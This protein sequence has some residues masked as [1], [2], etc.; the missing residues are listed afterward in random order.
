MAAT[1]GAAA[2]FSVA[3]AAVNY[4]MSWLPHK[5][6]KELKRHNLEMERES[7]HRQHQYEERQEMNDRK[8]ERAV[9]TKIAQTAYDQSI[10]D[11]KIYNTVYKKPVYHP[12]LKTEVKPGK[13][14]IEEIGL[15][16][17]IAAGL[18]TIYYIL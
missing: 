1:I 14:T 16:V 11:S 8:I 6:N 15:V 4:G 5:G 17:G 3:S 7:K 18:I 9:N 13:H 2:A 12:I 10:Y